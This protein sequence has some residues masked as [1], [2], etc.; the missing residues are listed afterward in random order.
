VVFAVDSSG[1]MGFEDRMA[2]VKGAISSLLDRAYQARNQVALVA[3]AGDGAQLAMRPT[4]SVE[5]ARAR[6]LDLPTGGRTPLAAGLSQ[7][8]ATARSAKP[9]QEAILVVVSDGRATSGTFEDAITA[10]EAIRAA[11]IPGLVVDSELAEPRLNLA[12]QLAVSM[13]ARLIRLEA[14]A[15]GAAI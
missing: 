1:S 7:A 15:S 12:S 10:A 4:S 14:L 3:F 5:V 9:D 2:A 8:L 11:G 13:G 6:L